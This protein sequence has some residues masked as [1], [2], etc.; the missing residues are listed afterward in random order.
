MVY[1]LHN[2]LQVTGTGGV[3]CRCSGGVSDMERCCVCL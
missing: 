3:V 1:I 2:T